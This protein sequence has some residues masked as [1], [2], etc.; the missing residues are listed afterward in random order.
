MTTD[1]V[2]PSPSFARRYRVPITLGV[3]VLV[4]SI[5]GLR[6]T[7]NYLAEQPIVEPWK[8][9]IERLAN[10]SPDARSELQRYL[11][12]SGRNSVASQDFQRLCETMVRKAEAQG[13]QVEQILRDDLPVC[14]RVAYRLQK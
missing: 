3:L 8:S 4:A 11:A 12:A 13:V 9:Y 7:L 6:L 1:S 2:D 5:V 10:A 14:K